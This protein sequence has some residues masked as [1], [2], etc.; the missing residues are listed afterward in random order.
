MKDNICCS[1]YDGQM[2]RNQEAFFPLDSIYMDANTFTPTFPSSSYVDHMSSIGA[3]DV[4]LED[5]YVTYFLT[6]SQYTYCRDLGEFLSGSNE[7]SMDV[8]PLQKKLETLKLNREV[9]LQRNEYGS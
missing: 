7:I 5:K 2:Q 3:L 9:K 8:D 6:S 4:E 1:P